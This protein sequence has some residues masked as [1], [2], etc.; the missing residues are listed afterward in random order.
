MQ[1]SSN[2][3]GWYIFLVLGHGIMSRGVQRIGGIIMGIIST[4][5]SFVMMKFSFLMEISQQFMFLTA[6]LWL[7]LYFTPAFYKLEEQ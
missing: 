1:N 2:E 6:F 5:I 7:F 4:I 3:E